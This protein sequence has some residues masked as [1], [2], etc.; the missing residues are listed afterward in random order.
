MQPVLLERRAFKVCLGR[1]A[2][3]V[4]L[5]RTASMELQVHKVSWAQLVP[6]ARMVPTVRTVRT[7]CPAP[8]VHK[9]HR[10]PP[11]Q[12]GPPVLSD[13]R[14]LLVRRVS[15]EQTVPMA[16][17]AFKVRRDL[18]A[19][20]GRRV[21]QVRRVL[22]ASR[23]SRVHKE[24]MASMVLTEVTASRVS[25]DHRE[26]L[27]RQGLQVLKDRWVFKGSMVLTA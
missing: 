8:P 23:V 24:L 5:D 4:L 7:V 6:P 22:K 10:V 25:Q 26:L 16:W 12:Q 27:V 13:H 11:V 17:M 21:L 9:V 2:T 19:L 14:D 20:M 1:T 15:T 3:T 18:R